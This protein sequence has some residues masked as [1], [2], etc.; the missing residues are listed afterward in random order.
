MF[1][2]PPVAPAPVTP[3]VGGQYPAPPSDDVVKRRQFAAYAVAA[4]AALLVVGSFLPWAKLTAPF[5][6]SVTKSGIEDGG[7]GWISISLGALLGVVAWRFLIAAKAGKRAPMVAA[8]VLA[9][10]AISLTVYEWIDIGNALDEAKTS[11]SAGDGLPSDLGIG[12]GDLFRVD[13]AVGLY[14]VGLGGLAG[15]AGALAYKQP[16]KG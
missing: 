2:A 11:L 10:A 16:P 8:V 7:D 5:F 1:E 12:L 13:Q 14:V 9:V 15:G 6:G 4:G 3:I